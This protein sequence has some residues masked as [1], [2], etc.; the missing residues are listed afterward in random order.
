MKEISMTPLDALSNRER[1]VIEQLLEGKSNKLIAASLGITQRT[2]EFHLKNIY[3]KLQVSSRVELVLKLGQS[4]VVEQ[5]ADAENGDE[6]NAPAWIT[7]LR[8]A[9]SPIGM[10]KGMT[11]IF[12][13]ER[14]EGDPITFFEAIRICLIQYAE[15]N[16]RATRP[17]FWWFTLFMM[18]VAAALAYVSEALSAVFLTAVLLP[19]L[20]VGARRLNDTGN[21]PWWLLF[22]FVPIG[23][24]VPAVFWAQPSKNPLPDITFMEEKAPSEP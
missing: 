6:S 16:G 17:E 7:S 4:T 1:E 2:V 21:S 20:A 10:E 15:F 12:K 11:S 19:F 22:L 8:K 24:V 3:D 23:F 14:N 18:L 5:A 13:L 9:V